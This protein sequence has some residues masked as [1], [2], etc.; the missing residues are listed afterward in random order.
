[1]IKIPSRNLSPGCDAQ[2]R[3]KE[4]ARE[5]IDLALNERQQQLI[6]ANTGL[7]VTKQVAQITM[8]NATTAAT[9]TL[10]QANATVC[11]AT[12]PHPLLNNSDELS[13]D[14]P[15]AADPSA[16][17]PTADE[18]PADVPHLSVDGAQGN[19]HFPSPNSGLLDS[20]PSPRPPAARW[21]HY[22][23]M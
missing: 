9:V 12:W 3:D 5:D 23:Y 6:I 11:P 16:D 1:V 18:P 8:A 2:V 21:R 20:S 17:G 4:K 22:V 15:R 10:V 13:A 19:T 7:N 14:E